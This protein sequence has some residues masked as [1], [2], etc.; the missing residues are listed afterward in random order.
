MTLRHALRAAALLCC[1]VAPVAQAQDAPALLFPVACDLGATCFIQQTMDRD[2]GPGARDFTCGPQSY[3]GH[4]GTDIRVADLADMDAGVV[5]LAAADG[6]VR[7]IRD[8]VPDR[9]TSAAPAGQ[10]CG[11]GIAITHADGWETQYC[12]LLRGSLTVAVG[13]TVAAGT[14][15]AQI[16]Y[17]GRTEFPHLEFILRRDGVPVDPFA[18]DDL[19]QCGTGAAPLWASDVEFPGGG[20]LDLGFSDAI[21]EF[22]AIKA[23]TASAAS[24][25]AAGP[26]LVLWGYVYAG[27]VGDVIEMRIEAPDGTLYHAQDVTLERTQAELFRASGR[28]ISSALATGA[29][30]GSVT[31][32]RDGAVLDQDV[33]VITLTE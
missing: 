26:A 9:G 5:V 16:G 22:G 19:S 12:H 11:N 30:I 21:P 33:T 4:T 31:L 3:D 25:S 13:D 32:L 23:G 17:S 10:N 28:R 27:R 8:G 15:L 7:A 29:Y 20:L 2:P 1:L 18:P 6:V 24:L 14:P